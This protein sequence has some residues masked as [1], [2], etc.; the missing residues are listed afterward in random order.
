MKAS[1]ATLEAPAS[2]RRA[3]DRRPRWPSRRRLRRRAKR[4]QGRDHDRLQGR[5]RVRLRAG[6]RRCPGGA[7]A[8]RGRQGEEREEAVGRDDR[9]QGRRARTCGSSATAAATTRSPTALKE[10]RRLMEQLRADVMIGPLSG[11]EAVSVA[12]YAKSHPTKTFIIGTAGSQDPTLQIAPKNV[13]RY[14]GDGAQWNAGIGEIAYKRLGWRNAAIIMDDY[15]F[16]WTSAAGHH[17]RLLRDRRQDHEAGVPAAQHDRL[18]VVRPAAPVARQRRRVL[19]G[20]RRDGHLGEPE[21]VRADLRC[22]RPEDSTSGTC[23]SRSS[24][25]TRSSHR[26][27][28]APTSAAS[29]PARA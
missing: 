4:G 29:A 27:S 11:D 8:V 18:R 21:G 5:V 25:R 14:H 9:H 24:G 3:R 16:G 12:N 22:A 6:H 20:R 13:F 15:S 23:S 28:S 26:R 2:A 1:H 10:T 19:L 7:R 17:R